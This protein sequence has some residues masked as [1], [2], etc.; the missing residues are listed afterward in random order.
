MRFI[1]AISGCYKDNIQA[2]I[3]GK[4]NGILKLSKN[5]P[6]LILFTLLSFISCKSGKNIVADIENKKGTAHH[7]T[8]EDTLYINRAEIDKYVLRVMDEQQIPGMQIVAT[9]AGK[10]VYS[11]NFGF[12]NLNH[13]VPVTDTTRFR[14]GSIGKTATALTI[15]LLERDGLL[16]FDDPLSVFFPDAPPHWADIK[17][18]NLLD[19]TSGLRD[20][21]LGWTSNFSDEEYLTAAYAQPVAFAPGEYN[22]YEN[23]NYSLLGIII[24][25]VSGKDWQT[26][27]QERLFGPLGMRRT[28]GVTTRVVVPGGA[29]GYQRRDGRLVEAAPEF[30]QSVWNLADGSLWT[31]AHDWTLLMSNYLNGTLFDSSYIDGVLLTSRKLN[32]GRP[33][34]YSFGHWIGEI[35]GT[36]TAEHGGGVPGFRTFS[37]IYPDKRLTLVLTC[38]FSECGEKEIAHTVAGLLD[39]D[40]RIS[41]LTP[42]EVSN[43]ERF[44]GTYYYPGWGETKFVVEDGKL[45]HQSDWFKNE[46]RMYSATGC[47]PDGEARFEFLT[48]DENQVEALIYYDSGYDKGWWIKRIKTDQ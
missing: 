23:V 44:S 40:L 9:K 10:V 3:F 30:S 26:F 41:N 21:G 43:P 35:A 17:V 20:P 45:Y 31:T 8:T 36:R 27:K 25:R 1:I 18:L 6:F 12:A 5:K 19:N 33:V 24:E 15:A 47:S 39:P 46:C 38:N 11:G 29:Q 37:I 28:H 22:V 42:V 13:L 34:N 32:S 48:S 7:L 4:N 2:I 14:S 16:S